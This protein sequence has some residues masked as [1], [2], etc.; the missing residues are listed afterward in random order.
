[1]EML[2]SAATDVEGL[3]REV[4]NYQPDTI[5]LEESSPLSAAPCLFN[6][7]KVLH[8]RPVVLVSPHRNQM[9]VVHWRT[10]E[11]ETASDL[12]KPIHFV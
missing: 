4:L 12:F 6:L 11:V 3:L 5:L 8:G 1:M 9:H 2:D 7:L 10:I